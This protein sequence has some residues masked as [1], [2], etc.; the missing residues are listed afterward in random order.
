MLP[1]P[2]SLQATLM[3]RPHPSFHALRFKNGCQKIFTV[4][5]TPRRMNLMQ[6]ILRLLTQRPQRTDGDTQISYLLWL[7][8]IHPWGE[9]I[10]IPPSWPSVGQIWRLVSVWW[11]VLPR[12]RFLWCFHFSH[13]QE[14]ACRQGTWYWMR[15]E[16]KECKR[17]I[18][19]HWH[20]QYHFFW[21]SMQRGWLYHGIWGLLHSYYW[22]FT[23]QY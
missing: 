16:E 15:N 13:Y 21:N 2:S 14:Y 19:A 6:W 5:T 9:V 8:P 17:I 1:F 20:H 11:Y 18:H 3:R 12:Y 22:R 10:C 7:V 23:Y 4:C